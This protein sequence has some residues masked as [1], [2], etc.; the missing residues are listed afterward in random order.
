[1]AS[2]KVMAKLQA[3]QSS[4]TQLAE[5]HSK[6]GSSLNSSLGRKVNVPQRWHQSTIT[7]QHKFPS[8]Q[9]EK[10]E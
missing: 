1:M 10:G 4:I 9:D 3:E 6:Q 5:L 7:A 2:A 8:A